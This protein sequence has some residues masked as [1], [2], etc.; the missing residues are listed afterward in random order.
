MP[1]PR[2]QTAVEKAARPKAARAKSTITLS[3][4]TSFRL[5]LLAARE[6]RERGRKVTRSELVEE[7]LAPRVAG[8]VLSVRGGP[9]EATEAAA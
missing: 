7:I 2:K 9:E 5:D 3:V 4:E 6:S 8:L 1:K